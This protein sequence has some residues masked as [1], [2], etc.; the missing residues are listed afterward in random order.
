MKTD[1][2]VGKE[3]TNREKVMSQSVKEI[4]AYVEA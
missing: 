2:K 1:E 4:T 3:I